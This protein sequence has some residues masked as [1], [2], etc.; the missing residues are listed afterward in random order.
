VDGSIIKRRLP[1]EKLEVIEA[2]V[3]PSEFNDFLFAPIGKQE[4]ETPLSVLSALS[5]LDV[6]PWHEAARVAQLPKDQAIQ[7]LSSMISGM[8]GGRW[9]A[10]DSIMIAA[11]LVELLPSRKNSN[12][13]A[14]YICILI[15]LTLGLMLVIFAAVWGVV[16]VE[17]HL[18]PSNTSHAVMLVTNAVAPRLPPLPPSE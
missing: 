6:D 3:I 2:S 18:L 14:D 9:K 10:S 7:D 17:S 15:I 13:S 11:R 12:A 4:N 5:R 8:P 1:K 16:V